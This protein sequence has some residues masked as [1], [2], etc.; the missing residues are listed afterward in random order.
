MADDPLQ[1]YVGA[2]VKAQDGRLLCQLRDNFPWIICPGTWCCCP[3]GHLEHGESLR[4]AV[5]RELW[6]EFEIKVSGL[7]P[8]LTHIEPNGPYR[9][10]YHAFVAD[11]ET[12]LDQ[13]KCN[14]G[15]K[16]EFF[17]PELA[18]TLPQHPVSALF[19]ERYLSEHL[20]LSTGNSGGAERPS[21]I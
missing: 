21:L 6:E 4:G 15:V 8:L 20:P 5:L 19:V 1:E 10:R 3:G 13:V 11:L 18:L 14:E 17:C 7:R 9:G 16:A 12:P 2:I